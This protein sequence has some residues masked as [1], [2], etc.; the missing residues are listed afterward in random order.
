MTGVGDEENASQM[1]R[2]GMACATGFAECG[3]GRNGG[4]E[5][6]RMWMILGSEIPS[7]ESGP[8]TAH[9]AKAAFIN[10][11]SSPTTVPT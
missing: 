5:E 11:S 3:G 1:K 7:V 2:K 9:N 8:H 10:N 6:G 4:R